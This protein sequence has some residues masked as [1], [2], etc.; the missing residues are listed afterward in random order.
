MNKDYNIK[1]KDIYRI[2]DSYNTTYYQIIN[3]IPHKI[4]SYRCLKTGNC[5]SEGISNIGIYKED[6]ELL[7]QIFGNLSIAYNLIY[8]MQNITK[9]TYDS[10]LKIGFKD[11]FRLPGNYTSSS[12]RGITKDNCLSLMYLTNKNDDKSLKDVVNLITNKKEITVE[13]EIKKEVK[14]D[15]LYICLEPTSTLT[16]FKLYRFYDNNTDKVYVV[17]DNNRQILIHKNRFQKIIS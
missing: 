8:T 9:S 17:N 2:E 16:K 5:S 3:N 1:G 14:I 10:L 15:N 13:K 12:K 7:K 11:Y 4:C 6:I